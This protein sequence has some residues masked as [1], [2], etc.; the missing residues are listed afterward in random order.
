L[1][2]VSPARTIDIVQSS[3][4]PLYDETLAPEGLN[5]PI[6]NTKPYHKR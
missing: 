5:V 2:D 3:E 6:G 4:Y 1:G